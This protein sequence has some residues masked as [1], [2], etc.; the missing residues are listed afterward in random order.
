MSRYSEL[1]VAQGATHLWSLDEASGTTLLDSIGTV[2]LSA[3]NAPTIGA[4]AA[5]G[6]GV[7]MARSSVQYLTSGTTP[8]LTFDVTKPLS[9]SWIM[10]FNGNT[11]SNYAVFSRRVDINTDRTFNA[12]T[13]GTYGGALAIDLGATNVR[14]DTGWIPERSRWYH[15]TFTFDH[16]TTTASLYI[17]GQL[18]SSQ[19]MPTVQSQLNPSV[20]YIGILGGSGSSSGFS[21]TIDE[22]A[23]FENKLLSSAEIAA[24]Y[25]TAFPIIRVF[26]GTTWN[27]ADR[28]IL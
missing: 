18:F 21:G 3:V 11:T 10:N 13:Y 12:F 27:D 24:Q 26:N 7:T 28:R 15:V 25:N 9:F 19:S 22:V 1:I 2:H 17:N 23:I 6:K 16:T 8:E 14:W 5:V 20:F 4:L